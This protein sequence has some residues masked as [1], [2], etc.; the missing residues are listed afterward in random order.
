[1]DTQAKRNGLE[2]EKVPFIDQIEI[3][4]DWESGNCKFQ[5]EEIGGNI[6]HANEWMQNNVTNLMGKVIKSYLSKINI[7]VL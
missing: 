7:M 1:M 2:Q 4:L 5:D 6:N 3:I